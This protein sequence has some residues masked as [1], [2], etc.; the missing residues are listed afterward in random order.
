M[1]AKSSSPHGRRTRERQSRARANHF[2]SYMSF[3]FWLNDTIRF[4]T[5]RQFFNK[6]IFYRFF[7]IFRIE[8]TPHYERY[9]FC[10]IPYW[11]ERLYDGE[12]HQL[13]EMNMMLRNEINQLKNQLERRKK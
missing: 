9:Y 13:R 1:S 3:L 10:G 2:P 8:Q 6:Q 7:G 11:F 12:F 4:W 5:T